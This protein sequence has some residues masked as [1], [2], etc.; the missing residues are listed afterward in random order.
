MPRAKAKKTAKNNMKKSTR[1]LLLVA[2]TTAAVVATAIVVQ[3]TLNRKKLRKVSNEGYETA[4]DMLYP[5]NAHSRKLK[6]GPVL[7][8]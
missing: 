6:Y 7:P 8:E 5:D 2:V 1:S 3:R 4:I